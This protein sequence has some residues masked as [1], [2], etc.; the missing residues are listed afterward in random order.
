MSDG[1]SSIGAQFLAK[2]GSKIIVDKSHELASNFYSKHKYKIYNVLRRIVSK[3]YL[4]P[5]S[6]QSIDRISE[7]ST[8]KFVDWRD[9]FR[10]G[11]YS[12]E[13]DRE[14]LGLPYTVLALWR[15]QGAVGLRARQENFQLKLT[16]E[17]WKATIDED[18]KELDSDKRI[19][20]KKIDNRYRY[21][22][23]LSG[24]DIVKNEMIIQKAKY[25]QQA[26]SNLLADYRPKKSLVSRLSRPTIREI[27]SEECRGSLP[28]LNDRRLAN[29][30]GVSVLI[31][32]RDDDGCLRPLLQVREGNFMAMSNCGVHCTG[33]KAADWP[34]HDQALEADNFFLDEAYLAIKE[35][36]GLLQH[37]L[38]GGLSMMCLLREHARLGKPQLFF[39][40]YTNKSV[41]EIISGRLREIERKA[42]NKY[43]KLTRDEMKDLYMNGLWN[44][45][46]KRA[47]TV[48]ARAMLAVA[49][50]EFGGYEEK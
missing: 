45:A 7:N 15:N 13:E 42:T 32:F 36:F 38:D 12:A 8:M 16:D 26:M 17:Q 34:R 25:S 41:D 9:D 35:D 21:S 39:Y 49:A 3:K 30:V 11:V 5:V 14:S 1:L 27:L 20:D 2:V 28:R 37:D 33:S 40:G 19:Y 23:R 18:F 29:T 47:F 6:L 43:K 22:I 50:K 10:D 31:F 48:E 4:S 44:E 24:F 46:E